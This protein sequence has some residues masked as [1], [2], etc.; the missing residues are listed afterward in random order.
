MPSTPT[1]AALRSSLIHTA[2]RLPK[3]DERRAKILALLRQAEFPADDIG[4]TKP[5]ALE[6]GTPAETYQ[7]DNFTQQEFHEL[8]EKQESGQLG[9]GTPDTSEASMPS[10]VQEKQ[11]ER[12]LYAGLVRLAKTN[13]TARPAILNLLREAGYIQDPKAEKL[14][15]Q[16]RASEFKSK[17]AVDKKA[18]VLAAMSDDD[19]NLR[20]G[21]IRMAKE[22]PASQQKL[23]AMIVAFDKEVAAALTAGE[24]PEAFKK[25]WKGDKG[26]DAKK[27]DAKDEKKDDKGDDDKGDDSGKPWE[28]KKASSKKNAFANIAKLATSAKEAAAAGFQVAKE[29]K[30]TKAQAIQAGRDAAAFW[31]NQEAA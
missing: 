22:K 18:A 9:N 5:G 16:K 8:G 11:A 7:D 6:N 25:N 1:D 4:E 24:V 3:G 28:K 15:Q 14:A 19:R 10:G 21:L 29:A 2:A 13:A 20:A 30:A 31:K 26:D 23:I 17:S 12:A 27:D